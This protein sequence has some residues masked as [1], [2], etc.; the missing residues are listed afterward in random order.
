[1]VFPT[2]GGEA[3]KLENMGALYASV[4]SSGTEEEDKITFTDWKGVDEYRD[5][6][7]TTSLSANFT[8]VFP[9]EV[10]LLNT[11]VKQSVIINDTNQ[12]NNKVLED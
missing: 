2:G 3:T 10:S 6:V 5:L 8:A 7:D 1:M 9:E 11:R 12:D 4:W